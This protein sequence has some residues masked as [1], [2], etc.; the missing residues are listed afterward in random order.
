MSK[1]IVVSDDVYTELQRMKKDSSFSKIIEYLIQGKNRRGDIA[2]LK[3]FFGV[4]NKKD[5]K[6]WLKEVE[7]GRKNAVGRKF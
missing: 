1:V 6:L 4:L 5:A 7:E 3:K 2:E